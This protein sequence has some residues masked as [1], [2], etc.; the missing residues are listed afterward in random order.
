MKLTNQ[1]Q[2]ISLSSFRNHNSG[3]VR[4]FIHHRH[5]YTNALCTFCICCI[6]ILGIGYN[7]LWNGVKAIFKLQFSSI[8]LLMTIAV[9]GAFY[10]KEFPE[11]AV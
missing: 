4:S 9:I 6:F 3:C 7:V 10:L 8:N 2:K 5:S 11:A 1:R